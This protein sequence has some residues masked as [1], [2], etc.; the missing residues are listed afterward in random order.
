MPP[1]MCAVARAAAAQAANP[2][3]KTIAQVMRAARCSSGIAQRAIAAQKAAQ[4]AATELLRQQLASGPKCAEH[5]EAAAEAA[6]ID[7]LVLVAAADALGVRTQRGQWWL[8]G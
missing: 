6:E 5:V 2:E 3:P 7:E 1:N 4:D 8:P